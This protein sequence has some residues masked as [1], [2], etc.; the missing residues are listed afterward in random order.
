MCCLTAQHWLV[1]CCAD[2]GHIS[3]VCRNLGIKKL[4]IG[5]ENDDWEVP[6]DELPKVTAIEWLHDRVP[7][8]S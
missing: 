1:A 3:L 8:T 4:Y 2:V 7:Q 6:K 5:G